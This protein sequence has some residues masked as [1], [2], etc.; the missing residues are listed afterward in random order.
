[1]YSK[2]TLTLNTLKILRIQNCFDHIKA[3]EARNSTGSRCF[4][5]LQVLNCLQKCAFTDWCIHDMWTQFNYC[6]QNTCQM[7][8]APFVKILFNII[9]SVYLC[10]LATHGLHAPIELLFTK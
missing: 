7:Y 5:I 6:V 3:A 2:V 1:M 8:G 4:V 9:S 10:H